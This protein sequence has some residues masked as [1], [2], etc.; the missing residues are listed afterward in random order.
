MKGTDTTKWFLQAIVEQP[1]DDPPRL[2]YARF[3]A[4]RGDPLGEFI[5]VQCGSRT[6]LKSL[7]S[8]APERPLSFPRFP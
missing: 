4:E 8:A 6:R 7:L 3:L 2:E 5:A 1:D